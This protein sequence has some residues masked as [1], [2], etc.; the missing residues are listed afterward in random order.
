[1]TNRKMTDKSALPLPENAL[2]I[3]ERLEA[4]GFEAYAVGGCVRDCLMLRTFSDVDITTNA[5]PAQIKQCF[6]DCKTVDIGEKYGTISVCFKDERFEITS[7]RTDGAYCDSRHPCNVAFSKN[8][9]DDLKRRDFTVNAM[10]YNPKCGIVDIFG[11]KTDLQSGIIR[12]VGNP[13]DRF[14]ED[15]LR[16]MRAIR[17]SSVLG[18][19]LEENTKKA[20]FECAHMLKNISPERLRDELVKLLCGKNAFDA[21]IEYADI[22]AVFIP[23]IKPCIGFCQHSVYH[24]YDVWEHIAH[25]VSSIEP[26]TDARLCALF[27]DIAKPECFFLDENAQGHFKGHAA[28]C[29]EK[30]QSI[31]KRLCFSS[32]QTELVNNVIYFHSDANYTERIVKRRIAKLG[33][34][35]FELLIKLQCADNSAKQDFCRQRLEALEKWRCYAKSLEKENACL[36]RRDLAINGNDVKECGFCGKKIGEV[37]DKL[38][39]LVVDEKLENDRKTLINAMRN[40]HT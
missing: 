2:R 39:E 21:L 10:A 12:C 22:L 6:C 11:S 16:I 19:K 15:A 33:Y 14:S 38:L 28:I 29:A 5:L 30:A 3:L 37:L 35:G 18:F 17:F 26:N 1:M 13:K 25:A 36:C 34:G 7:Y 9:A 20:A 31:M 23:E 4:N 27:H 8:L 40:M 32:K 24:K